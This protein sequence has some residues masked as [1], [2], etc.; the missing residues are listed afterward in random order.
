MA[1]TNKERIDAVN[2]ALELRKLKLA[3]GDSRSRVHYEIV[4]PRPNGGHTRLYGC[5]TLGEAE[6]FVA[7]L[8]Q[9]GK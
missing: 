1:G 5:R 8:E 6:A 3:D 7:G 2:R 4:K 9:G